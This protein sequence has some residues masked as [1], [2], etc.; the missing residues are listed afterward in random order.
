M[1]VILTVTETLILLSTNKL[2][3]TAM[4]SPAEQVGDPSSQLQLYYNKVHDLQI[5]MASQ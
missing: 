5:E 3:L 1:V 2:L 4:T